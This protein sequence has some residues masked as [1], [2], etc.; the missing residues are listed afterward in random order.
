VMRRAKNGRH[1][2]RIVSRDDWDGYDRKA[3]VQAY[4]DMLEA[5]VRSS[6]EMWLW[7]HR[8]FKNLTDY[9]GDAG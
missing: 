9:G 7:T 1:C 2:L 8:K 6:P 5:A 4:T 3:I